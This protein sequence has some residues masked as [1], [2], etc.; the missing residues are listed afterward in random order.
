MIEGIIVVNKPPKITSHDVVAHARRTLGIKKIGH[1][2]T[3]D[4]LATGVLV[5]LIGKA[6]K[7]CDSF[8]E[9]DKAYRATL[10]LGVRTD[11]L[12][13]LGKVLE[14]KDVPHILR[15]NVVEV[16]SKF[17]GD[18][19]Q[20]PPM[21]SAVSFQGKK[22][23][24]FARKGITIK[25]EPR[26]IN[27]NC[28]NLEGFDLPN[29]KIYMECS[30]G[31]YVRQLADDIGRELGCGA[32]ISQLQRTKVGPF[33]LEESVNIEDINESNIRDWKSS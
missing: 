4:P 3:L 5:L 22:L 20:I 26:K 14:E 29:L 24:K 1:A 18:I 9:F 16:L 6:T 17:T 27:I 25:R 28:L 8:I 21:F 12:D 2:G 31:T 13:I 19:E 32:C 7:L 33:T 30:K 15:E 11:T 23:Y 10:L